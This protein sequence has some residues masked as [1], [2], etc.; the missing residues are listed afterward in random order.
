MAGFATGQQ[1]RVTSLYKRTAPIYTGRAKYESVID[2]PDEW[3]FVF[4]DIV[5]YEAYKYTDDARAGEA[6]VKGGESSYSGQLAVALDGLNQMR[7]REPQVLLTGVPPQKDT[8]K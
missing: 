2:F 8:N 6:L 5:L 1:P 4:E 3:Y 7:L